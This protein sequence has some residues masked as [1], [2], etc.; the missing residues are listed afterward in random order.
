MGINKC[1]DAVQSQM[2]HS[3]F[4]VPHDRVLRNFIL[5][6]V[7]VMKATEAKDRG[8]DEKKG[9]KNFSGRWKNMT[10]LGHF[11]KIVNNIREYFI[12][13]SSSAGRAVACPADTRLICFIA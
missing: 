6:P 9:H 12:A 11:N 3:G 10:D 5:W 2:K 8:A 7:F 1:H 13:V 4:S